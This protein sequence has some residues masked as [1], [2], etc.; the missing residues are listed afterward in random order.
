MILHGRLVDLHIATLK[1]FSFDLLDDEAA[2]FMRHA[3]PAAECLPR[4]GQALAG[5]KLLD[6]VIRQMHLEA[7]GGHIR[8]QSRTGDAALLQ[9]H[10]RRDDGR[11]MPLRDAHIFSPD[12][13]LLAELR[14]HM[15]EQLRGL[16]ADAHKGCR[17]SHDL[18]GID[19]DLING[20]ALDELRKA[21][22][23]F[24]CGRRAVLLLSLQAVE[25]DGGGCGLWGVRRRHL[26][27]FEQHLELRGIEPLTR[28]AKE[29]LHQRVHLELEHAV[30]LRELR[31]DAL[32]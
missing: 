26:Q 18:G 6:A 22:L 28:L 29:P 14:G 31:D 12:D 13:V 9:P 1:N 5:V 25:A 2:G 3:H 8:Q 27:A 15:V 32:L 23:L 20:Q 4:H 24:A 17:I 16:R 30:V 19:D 10:Q 7:R 21:A 11:Q